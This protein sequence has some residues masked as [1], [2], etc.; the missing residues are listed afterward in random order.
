MITL[1]PKKKA[2][3]ETENNFQVAQVVAHVLGV[4]LS[5]VTVHPSSS[6]T[7]ANS[8]VTGGSI[9]SEAVAYVGF[10]ISFLFKNY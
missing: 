1:V 6:I 3:L 8:V 7:A 2:I 5:T 10:V 9:G 4:P